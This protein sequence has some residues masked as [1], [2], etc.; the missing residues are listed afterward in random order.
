MTS[1]LDH[2]LFS[3]RIRL[4]SILLVAWFRPKPRDDLR[5]L[6]SRDCGWI[7]PT[8]LLGPGK[9]CYCVGAGEDITL[10]IELSRAYGCSVW[11]FDPTP[12][13]IS[14]VERELPGSNVKFWPIGIWSSDTA[15]RFYAPRDPQHVSH[16]VV[17]LQRTTAF[18]EAPCRTIGSVMKEL[19]HS[20]LAFLKLDIE[21]AE[22]EVLADILRTRPAIECICVEFD[23]PSPYHSTFRTIRQLVSAGYALVSVDGLNCTFIRNQPESPPGAGPP[24]P[25]HTDVSTAG[26]RAAASP[27]SPKSSFRGGLERTRLML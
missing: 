8:R 12:R 3:L 6:G 4:L 19:G 27:I 20:S 21:G 17:N 23:Q 1:R 24:Q 7:V 26:S 16:S 2:A 11:I 9:I 15:L 25:S 18:F 22:H 14:H 13:A 5:R 10:D